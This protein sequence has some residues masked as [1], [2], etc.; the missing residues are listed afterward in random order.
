MAHDGFAGLST[1]S[2]AG[3]SISGVRSARCVESQQQDI[4]PAD[5]DLWGKGALSGGAACNWSVSAD[6]PNHGVTLAT[7]GTTTFTESQGVSTKAV[8]VANCLITSIGR[9]G[10]A[11]G[12]GRGATEISG[13]AYSS[14]G[15][16]SPVTWPS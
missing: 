16:A 3:V 9:M 6:K 15:S 12:A 1:V 13:V 2:I 7:S 4:R 11:R 8:S 5:N 14:D 10:T